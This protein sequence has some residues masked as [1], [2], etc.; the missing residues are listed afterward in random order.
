MKHCQAQL[1]ES[2]PSKLVAC[3]LS[4]Q[5]WGKRKKVQFKREKSAADV[6]WQ[7]VQDSYTICLKV[8]FLVLGFLV[9]VRYNYSHL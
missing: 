7:K 4:S 3:M 2:R 6:R 1:T 9:P 5:R 8:T